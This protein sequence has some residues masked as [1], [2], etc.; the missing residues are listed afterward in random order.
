MLQLDIAKFLDYRHSDV[1]PSGLSVSSVFSRRSYQVIATRVQKR[2]YE[3]SVQGGQGQ[4]QDVCDRDYLARL[5]LGTRHSIG[6]SPLGRCL[7]WGADAAG[8]LGLG[9]GFSR[10]RYDSQGANIPTQ[11][12]F[13]PY[14]QIRKEP[15]KESLMK[16]I[17][18]TACQNH[19]GALVADFNDLFHAPS[20]SAFCEDHDSEDDD[21]E[22]YED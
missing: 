4:F 3:Q 6:V 14:R 18:V 16:A 2:A 15:A 12:L 17:Q 21:Y 9:A 19:S 11:V 5:A 7:A 8:Q 20:T 1:V 10:H 13:E 22:D